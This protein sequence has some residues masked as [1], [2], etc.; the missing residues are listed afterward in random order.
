MAHSRILVC[1]HRVG[2]ADEEEVVMIEKSKREKAIRWYEP[3]S[4]PYAKDRKMMRDYARWLKQVNWQLI[5]TF[6]FG[7]RLSDE[8]ANRKFAE[9]INRLEATIK[10]DVSYVRGD[11]KR[12]SGC[13]KPACGRHF[14]VVMTSAAPL[15][16]AFVEWLWRDVAGHRDDGADVQPYDAS[17][18]A[19]PYVLKMMDKLHG[20]WIF[21][22]LHLVFP[23]SAE[24][25]NR[26]KRRH[27]Q[28]HEARK[29]F[30]ASM[31]PPPKLPE[32]I[33]PV[34]LLSGFLGPPV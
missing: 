26:Q 13:G 18:N 33:V 22:N 16:P 14:H 27:L 3:P 11:E 7:S 8:E 12:F 31:S 20:D 9:F 15:H 19:V 4:W 10:A 23:V 21:R 25:L 24:I 2:G 1:K 30:F 32:P 5:A 29:K 6:T 28:R 34:P 17:L